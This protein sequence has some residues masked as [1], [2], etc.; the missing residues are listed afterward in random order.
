MSKAKKG[1]KGHPHSE[2]SKL[3]L[4]KAHKGRKFTE[5][6]NKKLSDARRR[7]DA[8]IKQIVE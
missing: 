2:E 4:S 1:K 3:K 7:R 5:E 6:H 8:K